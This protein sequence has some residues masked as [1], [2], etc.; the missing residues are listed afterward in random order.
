MTIN[1]LGAGVA[2]PNPAAPTNFSICRLHIGHTAFVA[3]LLAKPAESPKHGRGSPPVGNTVRPGHAPRA[4]TRQERH[5]LVIPR[6]SPK[7]TPLCLRR[8]TTNNLNT[9]ST[10][11]RAYLP[12]SSGPPQSGPAGGHRN[13]ASEAR[14]VISTR[15]PERRRSA[16]AIRRA[17]G[18][19]G[20]RSST[21]GTQQSDRNRPGC[22]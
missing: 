17:Q 10:C 13:V 6:R 3:R 20:S 14:G 1:D 21:E 15:V 19:P 22:E 18:A 2:A 9:T 5:R 4:I 16:E 12:S 8:V 7:L 11:V